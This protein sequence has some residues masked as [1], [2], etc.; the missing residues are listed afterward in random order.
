R[1]GRTTRYVWTGAN[2]FFGSLGFVVPTVMAG[3]IVALSIN[4]HPLKGVTLNR[5]AARR[6]RVISAPVG[7]PICSVSFRAFGG[8]QAFLAAI[9]IPRKKS[10]TTERT[11]EHGSSDRRAGSPTAPGR[12]LQIL[13]WL[14]GLLFQE[15]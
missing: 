6:A 11:E 15:F 7:K 2:G 12:R 10:K 9:P 4:S 8:V 14:R 5:F 1:R 3:V 13:R